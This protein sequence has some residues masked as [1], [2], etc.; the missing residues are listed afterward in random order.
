MST[1]K[2]KNKSKKTKNKKQ[3]KEKEKTKFFK[4][5]F[6]SLVRFMIAFETFLLIKG[7]WFD[8]RYLRLIGTLM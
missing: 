2:R 6:L 3:K 4:N 7:L 8:L 5:L 1:I